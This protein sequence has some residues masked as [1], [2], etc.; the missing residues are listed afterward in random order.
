VIE[1]CNIFLGQKFANT[2]RFVGGCIIVQQEKI[3][4]AEHSWTNLLNVLQE[5]IHYSFIKFCIYCFSFWYDFFVHYALI[6]DKKI[7]NMVLMQDLW[8][9]SFFG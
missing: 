7:I 4:W 2:C 9:F 5:V 8:N 1:G 6:V 3:S